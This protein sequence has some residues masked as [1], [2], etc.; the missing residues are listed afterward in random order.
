MLTKDSE[1]SLEKSLE[2]VSWADE[3]VIVDQGSTDQTIAIAKKYTKTIFIEKEVRFDL[4]RNLGFA[5][6]TNPWV[7]YLDADEVVSS[8]LKNEI[9]DKC[10]SLEPKNYALIRENFFLGVKM[11]PDQVERIFHRKTFKEWR[12]KVHE[13]PIFSGDLEILKHPLIH[14]THRTIT[15][16]LDKTNQWS[17]IEANLRLEAKHPPI[18]PWRVFRIGAT[19]AYHQFFQKKVYRYG[20]KGWI[21]GLFQIMDKMIIFVKLWELQQK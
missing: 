3:I 15:S 9:I 10:Q 16:M 6:T 5:K 2:S 13:T 21:E 17:S 4:R 19:E 7:M 11:Y 18:K 1:E 12:G 14:T 8:K 20:S